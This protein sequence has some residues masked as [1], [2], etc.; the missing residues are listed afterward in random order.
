MECVYLSDAKYLGDF[1]F[2]LQF[3]DG[4]KG[5]VNL[6]PIIDK[7]KQ[8]NTLK[9]EKEVAKFYL[10][11]WPTLAWKCGFDIAPEALY[12]ECERNRIS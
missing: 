4:L 10:D 11:S 5:Q 12:K 3:N 9:D 2:V 6:K 7:Y 8:A 1:N